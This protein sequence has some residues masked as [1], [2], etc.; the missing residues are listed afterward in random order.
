MYAITTRFTRTLQFA[1]LQGAARCWPA[2][3]HAPPR[4]G[5]FAGLDSARRLLDQFIPNRHAARLHAT[6]CC[7]LWPS[8]YATAWRAIALLLLLR[9]LSLPVPAHILQPGLSELLAAAQRPRSA[10][11]RQS[12]AQRWPRHFARQGPMSHHHCGYSGFCQPRL[13]R[14]LGALAATLCRPAEKQATA[15]TVRTGRAAA[16]RSLPVRAMLAS[17]HLVREIS[18]SAAKSLA[19]AS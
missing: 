16:G 1:R 12:T 3:V 8:A 18:V 5:A 9:Q 17:N 11:R 14:R 15:V 7:I 4:G 13:I 19:L 6:W 2:R 10:H